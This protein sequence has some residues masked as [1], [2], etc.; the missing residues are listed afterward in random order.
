MKTT[1]LGL[2][3]FLLVS[4]FFVNATTSVSKSGY[5]EYD[6]WCDLNDNGVIDIFDVVNVAGKYATTGEPTRN[7]TVTNFPLQQLEPAW[8]LIKIVEHFNLTWVPEESSTIYSETIDLGLVNTGGYSRM[9]LF[10]RVENYSNV[11]GTGGGSIPS[12]QN[13]AEIFCDLYHKWGSAEEL[14]RQVKVQ[15]DNLTYHQSPTLFWRFNYHE[16]MITLWPTLKATLYGVSRT[17]EAINLPTTISCLVSISIY[18][19][20]V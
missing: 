10:L 20:N 1:T 13:Y 14:S 2:A 16:E 8:K 9:M 3:T 5:G 11:G 19:R 4:L 15:W 6:P 17:P 12:G 7:V 18:L